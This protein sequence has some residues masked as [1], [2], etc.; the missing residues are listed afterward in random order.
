MLLAVLSVSV[1]VV[2]LTSL[3]GEAESN[4][5]Y[6]CSSPTIILEVKSP[7]ALFAPLIPPESW[8]GSDTATS[9]DK[10]PDHRD[11]GN[12]GDTAVSDNEENE[13]EDA[14]QS[15]DTETMAVHHNASIISKLTE[16]HSLH[17]VINVD[18]IS[19]DQIFIDVFSG[20]QEAGTEANTVFISFENENGTVKT[21]RIGIDED[22]GGIDNITVLDGVSETQQ[23]QQI[24]SSPD[25]FHHIDS[26]LGLEQIRSPVIIILPD[27]N[28]RL[29]FSNGLALLNHV[30]QEQYR[31]ENIRAVRD[32]M[33]I[34]LVK[35]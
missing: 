26:S 7:T 16:N 23:T 28:E 13:D 34:R 22:Q 9:D 32:E 10:N 21:V 4:S 2:V 31:I 35:K 25:E 33:E 18:N 15:D 12:S 20:D 29:Y 11:N 19:S 6:Y 3:A 1:I 17:T 5:R 24:A 8:D 14:Q 30:F 27:T